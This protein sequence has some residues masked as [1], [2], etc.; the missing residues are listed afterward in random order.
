M[1]NHASTP[2]KPALTVNDHDSAR[3][4]ERPLNEGWWRVKSAVRE[5]GV[6]TNAEREY[7]GSGH[8]PGRVAE[9]VGSVVRS[10]LHLQ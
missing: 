6:Q 3:N 4:A 5:V 2:A 1:R 10:A 7:P 8:D 9:S